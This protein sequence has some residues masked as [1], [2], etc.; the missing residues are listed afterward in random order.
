MTGDRV[1][2]SQSVIC[3]AS[4]FIFHFS[5]FIFHFL[6]CPY[7][8]SSSHGSRSAPYWSCSQ[9]H[10]ISLCLTST[11]T[12]N[13]IGEIKWPLFRRGV[14]DSSGDF[15]YEVT[16]RVQGCEICKLMQ[17]GRMLSI[18]RHA[19]ARREKVVSM[20]TRGTVLLRYNDIFRQHHNIAISHISLYRFAWHIC[21]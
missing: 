11:P 17:L 4:F 5:S 20:L 19:E 8:R 13:Q 10:S 7:I 6:P 3:P 18:S 14:F 1:W 15:F 9:S 12:G 2:H 16:K 21:H